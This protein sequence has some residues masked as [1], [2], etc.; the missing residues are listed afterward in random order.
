VL[1][2]LK[3]LLRNLAIYGMGDAA[4]SVVSLLLLPVYT[5]FLSPSDYGVIAMLITIEA[6]AKV[7][8]RWG[9]DTAFMRLYYDCADTA[10]RQQLASTIT[11]FLLAVNG[12]LLVAGAACSSWIS[13]WLFD[14]TRYWP[15]IVLTIL[16]TFVTGF[17]FIPMHVLRIGEQSGQ[18]VS[19][20]FG[21]SAGTLVMRLVLVVWAGMGV[22][23]VVVADIAVTTV[24]T[25][26]LA[27][28]FAPL[29]R[30]VFSRA[31]L[32]DALGFG[33]PRI[34]HSLASQVIGLAD[35]YF[36]NAY[37]T[38]RDVGLYSI[39]ATF[40]LAPKLLLS[41]FEYAWTPFFLGA[42]RERD[43]TRTYSVVSTYVM[44]LLVP[45]VATVGAVASD[46]IRLTT[47]AQ[48][49]AAAVVTPWIALSV[50]CQ[51]VYILGSIGIVI[52]KRTRMYPL[53]TGCAA[54]VG[55][56]ANAILVPRYGLMG[57]AWSNVIAYGTLTA[58][59][60]GV[61]W[62]LFPIPYEWGR[63][64]RITLGGFAGYA[65]ATMLISPATPPIVGLVL[66][67]VVTIAVYVTVMFATGFFHP[68]EIRTFKELGRRVMQ[69]RIV[70]TPTGG[71]TRE[72]QAEVVEEPAVSD[73]FPDRIG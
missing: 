4:T 66:R 71:G 42:M 32:R 12:L 70:P 57:A 19:L 27:R 54:A 48:F 11:I 31:I 38:L 36:L 17:Y 46:A 45:L 63:L 52:T 21:R 39:G 50:M 29:L 24:F 10:A 6:V 18:F 9:V 3:K 62:R 59:T 25:I 64:G 73:D 28:W 68:G 13:W 34:P 51:G 67:A 58:V 60:V 40:G 15:L 16:N 20:S 8:F 44:S 23:G 43:V 37:G 65:A 53:A 49:H 47:K 22:L 33:L 69:R 2:R 41:A 26:V 61:S 7:V 14:T 35:K 5:R 1:E 55:L 72:Q 30:P 56:L